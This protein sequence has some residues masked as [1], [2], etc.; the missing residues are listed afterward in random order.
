[1]R[2]AMRS[3]L[4]MIVAAVSLMLAASPA[5]AALSDPV[6]SH[7]VIGG[8]DLFGMSEAEA[9]AQ[10][11]SATASALEGHVWVST[12]GKRYRLRVGDFAR[13]DVKGMLE[14]AHAQ[15]STAPPYQL[16]RRCIVSSTAVNAWLK[17]LEKSVNRA[18]VSAA[19][20]KRDGR[21]KFRASVDGKRLD[22]ALAAKRLTALIR[23]R[24]E[25]D[26]S[27]P[28]LT[29]PVRTLT[30]AVRSS[31]IK[32]AII[33]DVS[34]RMLRLYERSR[35]LKEY[36][37]AVGTPS[38][39]TPLGT[40]KVGRKSPAPAWYNPGSAWARNMPSYIP[41]GPNNPLGLRALY[42]NSPGIRIH[43]TNNIR[44]LGTAASHGCIRVAN[45]NIVK[46]YPLVPVGTVVYVVK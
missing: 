28:T 4:V 14:R 21:L 6:P 44:S 39:P 45:S 29:L 5:V 40:L 8:V 17:R 34:S 46:L 23:A 15:T 20:L 27:R 42:L 2:P 7:A 11:T 13:T 3:L 25:A 12:S 9:R 30:P 16:K 35:L 1:M 32:R 18:P 33:V 24:Y 43:G 26:S 10:I 22:R 37:V 36:R 41:P 19:Y 38:H 31:E